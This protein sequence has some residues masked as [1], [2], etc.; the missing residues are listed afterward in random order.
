MKQRLGLAMALIHDPQIYVLDEPM[1][2]LDPL[3]RR[4]I[5]DVIL[6]LR[7]KGKTVFFSSHI[8]SD[9]ERLCDRVGI[10]NKGKLLDWRVNPRR[11]KTLWVARAGRREASFL[12]VLS[13]LKESENLYQI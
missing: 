5:T 6:E 10:L 9:V 11:R 12:I 13:H 8:L 1:T 3:G 4:K 2:G 7:Q